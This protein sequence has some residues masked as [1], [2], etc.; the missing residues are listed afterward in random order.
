MQK[1]A[2]WH[3]AHVRGPHWSP[4]PIKSE[5]SSGWSVRNTIRVPGL[6]MIGCHISMFGLQWAWHSDGLIVNSTSGGDGNRGGVR[7]GNSSLN[8]THATRLAA[9][10]NGTTSSYPLPIRTSAIGLPTTGLFS[11]ECPLHIKMWLGFK[12]SDILLHLFS[13][14]LEQSS[15]TT[16]F[17]Q[18]LKRHVT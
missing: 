9:P 13:T 2:V 14:Q 4:Q 15:E 16:E 11:P 8:L 10:K 3:Q 1:L 12:V 17:V 7:M 6:W 18:T 5:H